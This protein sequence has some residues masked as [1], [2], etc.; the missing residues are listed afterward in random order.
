VIIDRFPPGVLVALPIPPKGTALHNAIGTSHDGQPRVFG[1]IEG[2]HDRPHRWADRSFL[3]P[4][5]NSSSHEPAMD[6]VWQVRI[7]GEQL[8]TFA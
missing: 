4:S 2:I 3:S 6:Q 5:L 8:A 1:G 7:I